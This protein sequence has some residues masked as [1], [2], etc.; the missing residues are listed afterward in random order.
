M[1]KSVITQKDL[2]ELPAYGL[3]EAAGYLRLPKSTLRARLLG[4]RYCD[5]QG[6]ARRFQPVI[7]IADPKDRQLSKPV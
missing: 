4:Q 5:D 2:R 3:A 7:T 6:K 1:R